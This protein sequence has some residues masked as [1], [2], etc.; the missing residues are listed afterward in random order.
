MEATA[1]AV[2]HSAVQCCFLTGRPSRP[3]EV[4]EPD[5]TETRRRAAVVASP[6]MPH[7]SAAAT[8]AHFSPWSVRESFRNFESWLPSS[9][10]AARAT[11]T[12]APCFPLQQRF[13]SSF[14]PTPRSFPSFFVLRK[15]L[16]SLTWRLLSKTHYALQRLVVR[17][18]GALSTLFFPS[19]LCTALLASHRG[20]NWVLGPKQLLLWHNSW[21]PKLLLRRILIRSSR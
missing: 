15:W 20:A 13:G 19:P 9:A 5:P 4:S 1:A 21:G 18:S 14:D 12:E 2:V 16:S 3:V 17:S 6:S 7:W 8:A 11:T 10:A